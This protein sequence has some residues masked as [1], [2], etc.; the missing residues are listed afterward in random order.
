MGFYRVDGGEEEEDE[1]KSDA[2]S[3]RRYR[4]DVVGEK[5]REEDEAGEGNGKGEVVKQGRGWGGFCGR[6]K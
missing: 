3:V 5:L 4:I 6:G 1:G 2:G